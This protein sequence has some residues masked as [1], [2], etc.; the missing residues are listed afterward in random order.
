MDEKIKIKTKKKENNEN[1]NP[2]TTATTNKKLQFC[3]PKNS[4]E[5]AK[6][7]I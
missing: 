1:D 7:N 2:A 4:T 3:T 6:Q 5:Q